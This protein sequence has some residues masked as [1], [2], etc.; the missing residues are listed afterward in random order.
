MS[1]KIMKRYVK[2][3][4]TIPSNN[5]PISFT[6]TRLK[7]NNNKKT[8]IQLETASPLRASETT[9]MKTS[10]GN[11]KTLPRRRRRRWVGGKRE[12]G[13]V[14]GGWGGG[15]GKER[16]GRGKGKLRTP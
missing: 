14:R 5:Q 15:G 12:V 4:V 2:R 13:G 3:F 8:L 7:K 11:K 9:L 1:S 10:R 16:K 6:E